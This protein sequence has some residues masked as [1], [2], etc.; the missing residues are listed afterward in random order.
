MRRNVTRRTALGGALATGLCL[1]AGN[2]LGGELSS[3][4]GARPR[5]RPL[6][7]DG[8]TLIPLSWD[9]IEE[10]YGDVGAQAAPEPVKETPPET[11]QDDEPPFTPDAPAEPAAEEQ[12]KRRTRRTRA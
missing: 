9:A 1:G 11:A 12:P 8:K 6:P 4:D 7:S 3:R 5:V 2:L 10:F